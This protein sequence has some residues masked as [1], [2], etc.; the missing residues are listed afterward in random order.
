MMENTTPWTTAPCF[1]PEENMDMMRDMHTQGGSEAEY[2]LDVYDMM[3]QNHDDAG[4]IDDMSGV[5]HSFRFA[6]STS[7]APDAVGESTTNPTASPSPSSSSSPKNSLF[8]GEEGD[9]TPCTDPIIIPVDYSEDRRNHW[10]RAGYHDHEINP[11]V[12]EAGKYQCLVPRARQPAEDP[13]LCEAYRELTGRNLRAPIP[14]HKPRVWVQIRCPENPWHYCYFGASRSDQ[15]QP[16]PEP[17]Q[18]ER[19]WYPEWDHGCRPYWLAGSQEPTCEPSIKWARV[20]CDCWHCATHPSPKRR[21]V[22]LHQLSEIF[23]KY[24]YSTC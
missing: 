8:D 15:P 13:A 5:N 6:N 23:A 12:S 21:E 4:D 3:S 24:R 10:R 7:S 19:L 9:E 1:S 16:I 22:R 2:L 18:E 20:P 17:D 14:P 11:W